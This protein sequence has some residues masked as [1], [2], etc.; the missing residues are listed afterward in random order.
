MFRRTPLDFP[1]LLFLLS[2]LISTLISIHPRTSWLGYYTRF[3]GGLLSSLTYVGLF[4]SYI[5]N[6][7]LNDQRKLLRTL[8]LAGL[9]VT[10]YAIPE[11]FGHSASCLF[12][13]G[14]FDANC[15]VQDVQTRVFATFGQ[16]NWL[17]AYVIMLFPLSIYFVWKYSQ[18]KISKFAVLGSSLLVLNLFLTLLF[19]KS[20]SGFLG[21]IVGTGILTLGILFLIFKNR[22]PNVKKLITN[23][24]SLITTLLLLPL[25]SA[26]IFGTPFTPSIF[27]KSKTTESQIS[28]L[29]PP[30]SIDRLEQGGTDSGEIR[31]IVWDG[32]IKIWQ[33]YPLFG[34]GVE[35]FAYSYYQDRPVEHNLVSEWNFLYNKAHNEWLNFLANSGAVGLGT[36]LLLQGSILLL[37]LLIFIKQQATENKIFT[38]AL[39]SGLLAVHVSNFFGFSTVYISIL[40][41]LFP[42]FAFVMLNKPEA[43]NIKYSTA[44]LSHK[45]FLSLL[46]MTFVTSLITIKVLLIWFGDYTYAKARQAY[47][48]GRLKDGLTL[49]NRAI[50]LSPNEGLYYEMLA[51]ISVQATVALADAGEA[52]AASQTANDAVTAINRAI[53]LNPVH[54]NFYRTQT[55]IFIT[56][57]QYEP[58]LYDAALQ[59]LQMATRL[60]PTEPKLLYDMAAI[61]QNLE[62]T[63]EA[64]EKY[65]EAIE[66][67]PNFDTARFQL[68]KLYEVQG[69]NAEALEQYE[70]ILDNISP[71]N[72]T[73]QDRID[74]IATQE[75]KEK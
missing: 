25:L 46:F 26:L 66:L 7:T 65:R 11:H 71:D 2:Q 60:A 41:V 50:R 14:N 22:K 31:K 59:S 52:E 75:A 73:V 48:D 18:N 33:R 27:D 64:E 3:H 29:R 19:T 23:N 56:L 40:M 8:L 72:K 42:A 38:L 24:W 4:Y 39:G 49:I 74:F 61:Y 21:W 5:S 16:P 69:K 51:K 9:G 55:V 1:I 45:Q 30:T 54:L 13:S 63:P 20:R 43:S 35:T 62:A 58:S 12:I 28:D 57:A 47:T 68:G 6:I 37:L 10:L 44:K 32:A 34:A 36:Y 67:K 53:E 70:Y 17:A 15:W